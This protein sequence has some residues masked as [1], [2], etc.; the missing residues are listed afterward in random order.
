MKR[1]S[2][3]EIGCQTPAYADQKIMKLLQEQSERI[4]QAQL[5]ACEKDVRE[6]FEYFETN[7]AYWEDKAAQSGGLE[8]DPDW[9][10]LKERMVKDGS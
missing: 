10:A 2:D 7:V 5:E 6:L 1:I 4:A 9:Q 8:N 3:E